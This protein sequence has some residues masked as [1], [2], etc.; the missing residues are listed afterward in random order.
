[1]CSRKGILN[2]SPIEMPSW[3]AESDFSER[4]KTRRHRIYAI[5]R[6]LALEGPLTKY[7]LEKR[8]RSE[9]GDINYTAVLRSVSFL[10]KDHL[11]S[12]KT[13]KR[14][15]WI[16][17]ITDRGLILAWFQ[18]YL[19]SEELLKSLSRRSR[20]FSILAGFPKMKERAIAFLTNLPN[21]YNL[22]LILDVADIIGFKIGGKPG[23]I[24]AEEDEAYEKAQ[25]EF[26]EKLIFHLE[27]DLLSDLI[28]K[29]AKGELAKLR[30]E[31]LEYLKDRASEVLKSWDALANTA[32]L[33]RKKAQR[34]I[35]TL[36]LCEKQP[37]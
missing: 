18:H 26:F 2:M 29:V 6:V 7:G 4:E 8:L 12:V 20:V 3:L 5:L 30:K 16:C 36:G 22:W 28:E 34:L 11:I 35:N 9:L 37:R 24:E 23:T 27:F 21:L 19:S 15:A 32:Q 33:H 13:G 25:S 17:D 10:E 1:M 31:D 14:N